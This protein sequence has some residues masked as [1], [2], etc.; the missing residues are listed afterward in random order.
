MKK[1]THNS[2]T[3][4]K[5]LLR[6]AKTPLLSH[7]QE[8][9]Y[10]RQIQKMIT[11]QNICFPDRPK[12]FDLINL[13][14]EDLSQIE[15]VSNLSVLE[16]KQIINT[17]RQAR[18][19]LISSNLR[20]V[21][22]IARKYF[23]QELELLDL[24]QE[25]TIGLQKAVEKFDSNRGYRFS[26][27]A[28][29]WIRQSII[30]ANAQK[31]RPIRLPLYIQEKLAQ[32]YKIREELTANLE[33]VPTDDEI[34]KTLEISPEKIKQFLAWGQGSI[35]L[36]VHCG[37]YQNGELRDLINSNLTDDSITV[38]LDRLDIERLFEN[39]TPQQQKVLVMK[40]GLVGRPMKLT[41][42]ADELGITRQQVINIEKSALRKLN[43]L[44][45]L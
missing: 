3:L 15:A 22:S 21:V 34:A 36:D 26:T 38:A 4:S 25:G 9:V 20:L 37:I 1:I 29:W 10:G 45:R 44:Y 42:I 11:L 18:D 35:S 24:I 28:Y 30:K 31:H 7:E 19:L 41:Q 8:I 43:S 12:Y 2:D 40:F 13:S 39:L 32:I 14:L 5:F 23:R 6:I 27:Y 17:G 16:I 33:R